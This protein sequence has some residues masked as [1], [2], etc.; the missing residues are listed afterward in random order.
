MKR[1]E[2]KQR[3]REAKEHIGYPL[4]GHAVEQTPRNGEG[5]GSLAVHGVTESDTTQQLNCT[6]PEK[7]NQGGKCWGWG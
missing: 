1:E 2:R 5:K 3:Q 7:Q 4:N 6:E